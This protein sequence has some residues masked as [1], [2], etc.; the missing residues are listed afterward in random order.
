MSDL[1]SF[2]RDSEAFVILTIASWIVPALFEIY[3]KVVTSRRT[4]DSVLGKEL[5]A[6]F[7]KLQSK[8]ASKARDLKSQQ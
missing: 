2:M 3:L 6:F 1:L 5:D 4:R 8:W 7:E